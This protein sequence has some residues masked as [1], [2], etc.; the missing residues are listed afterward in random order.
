MF[1]SHLGFS[2]F[3]TAFMLE[4]LFGIQRTGSALY[5]CSRYWFQTNKVMR[6][7][8]YLILEIQ[9]LSLPIGN[10][11]TKP[12]MP[13]SWNLQIS[14]WSQ[15]ACQKKS[16]GFKSFTRRP[17][18]FCRYTWVWR[19]MFFLLRLNATTLCLRWAPLFHIFAFPNAI[20]EP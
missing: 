6:I 16:G 12:K 2:E 7:E 18:L 17:H 4:I 11:W 13:C 8:S 20:I 3:V 1:W 15:R 5:L 9:L 14:Y 10:R 19:L